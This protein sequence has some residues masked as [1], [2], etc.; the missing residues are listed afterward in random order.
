MNQNEINQIPTIK[1]PKILSIK[2]DDRNEAQN[3]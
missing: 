2:F 1:Q 3:N